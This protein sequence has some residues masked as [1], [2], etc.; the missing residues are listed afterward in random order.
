MLR[1][2]QDQYLRSLPF[3]TLGFEE[4]KRN[5]TDWSEAT[6]NYACCVTYHNFEYHPVSEVEQQRVE[7]GVLSK[8]VELRKDEPLYDLAI[9]GEIEPDG[10]HHRES[11]IVRRGEG[12]V[13][14]GGGMRDISDFE[15]FFVISQWNVKWGRLY[16][17]TNW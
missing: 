7:M 5:C 6:T 16:D 3:E 10:H 17:E 4:I 13:F 8:H 1:D 11:A 2:M 14:S 15:L 12:W 9:A